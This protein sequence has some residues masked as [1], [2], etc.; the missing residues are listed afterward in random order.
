MTEWI[1]RHPWFAM[2]IAMFIGIGIGAASSG[3]TSDNEELVGLQADLQAAH[4]ENASLQDEIEAVQQ[5]VESAEEVAE[6]QQEAARE[7]RERL[8]ARAARLRERMRKIAAEEQRIETSTIS[9]G[10]WQ[11]GVDIQPGLYRAPAGTGCYWALLGSA[12]TADIINNGGFGPN[13]TVQIDSPWFE[14]RDC[15]E[16]KKIG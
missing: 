5:Q 13:Q 1:A 8:E 2:A 7:L 9:D 14:T 10:I 3:E 11:V 4:A 15:G 6:Q 12:D 16:W